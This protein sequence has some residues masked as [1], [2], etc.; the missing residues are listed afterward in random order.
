MR[1]DFP[2]K[3]LK[4]SLRKASPRVS[5]ALYSYLYCLNKQ[6]FIRLGRLTAEAKPGVTN[7]IDFGRHGGS[8]NLMGCFQVKKALKTKQAHVKNGSN[9]G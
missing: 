4:S 6:K 9:P 5:N 7:S 8:G 2:N 3:R 1:A